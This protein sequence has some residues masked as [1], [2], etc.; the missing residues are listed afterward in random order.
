MYHST[1]GFRNKE[2][3]ERDLGAGEAVEVE[4]ESFGGRARGR[5]HLRYLRELLLSFEDL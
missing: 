5:G 2:R 3:E 4:R 1:V